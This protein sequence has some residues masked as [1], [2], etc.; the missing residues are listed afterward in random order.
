MAAPHAAAIIVHTIAQR[1]GLASTA[2]VAELK[3]SAQDLGA[4]NFDDTFGFG[5]IELPDA[6]P[7]TASR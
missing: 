5:L 6:A 2:V 1:D 3:R 4:E 7:V